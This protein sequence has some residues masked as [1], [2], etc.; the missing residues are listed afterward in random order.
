MDYFRGRANGFTI[1]E[2]IIAIVVIAAL[3]AISFVVYGGIQERA[4][5]TIAQTDIANATKQ[6][7]MFSS[8]Y[9]GYPAALQCPETEGVTAC[10]TPSAGT[11]LSYSANNAANPPTYSLTANRGS[12]RYTANQASSASE[13]TTQPVTVTNLAKNGDFSASLSNW[14]INCAN[15]GACFTIS[16]GA[17]IVSA[18]PASQRTML[19]QSVDTTYTDKDKLYYSAKIKKNGGSGFSAQAYR[20]TGGYQTSIISSAQFSSM[21]NGGVQ[22][23]SLVRTFDVTQ[24]AY[25]SMSFGQYTTGNDFQVEIDD[26]IAINL[27]KDFGAGKEPT[28]AQMDAMIASLPGGWFSATTT[29]YK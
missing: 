2:L 23:F 12:V 22:R 28:A 11:V 1:V 6:I 8:Q 16:G 25:T 17:A 10:F 13:V 7:K 19:Y 18:D 26:V 15:I 4:Q 29:L 3:A 27:T 14:T 24:G 20:T 9:G 5:K 21:S